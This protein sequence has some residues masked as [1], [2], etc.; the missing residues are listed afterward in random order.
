MVAGLPVAKCTHHQEV[1]ERDC[2]AVTIGESVAVPVRV[3]SAEQR[4]SGACGSLRSALAF[5]QVQHWL[6]A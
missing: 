4:S 3:S 1:E 6:Q 5:S 2:A